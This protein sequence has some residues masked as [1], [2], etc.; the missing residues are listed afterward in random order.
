MIFGSLEQQ[1][2]DIQGRLFELSLAKGIASEPFISEF[3]CGKVAAGLDLPYDR[4]QWMG[5]E[6]LLE[7]VM[8]AGDG[9][10][11]VFTGELYPREVLYWMG[12][13]Y[14][15]WHYYTDEP[16]AHIYEQ[17]PAPLML[18]VWPG[19]HTIDNEMAVDR[20]KE[21]AASKGSISNS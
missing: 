5:E 20:L 21:L 15:F 14:R 7:E 6:Y 9:T 8:D 3:M 16:S 2:C 18:E 1:L 13:L 10:Q 17:A 12:W 11:R 4:L 19:F